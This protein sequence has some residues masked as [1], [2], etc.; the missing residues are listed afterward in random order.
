MLGQ[1]NRYLFK[2]VWRSISRNPGRS[3]F[4]GFSVSLAVIIAVW[5]IAFFDGLNH[6]IEDAVV[7]ANV[8]TFQIQEANYARSTDS[9]HPEVFTEELRRKIS[10]YDFL[11][12]SP[13]LVLDSNI[14]TPEG[15]AG[16]ITIGI[17]PE[18]HKSFLP[19]GKNMIEGNFIRPTDEQE[20]VIGEELANEFKFKTGDQLVLNYQD[21]QGELRSEILNIKGIYR[22]NGNVFERRFAYISQ[23]TWQKL[24]LNHDSGKILFN[25]ITILADG[26]HQKND[27]K[28]ILKGTPFKLKTWKQLNPEMAVV[29]EFHDGMIK[30]FFLIIAITI[31]MT[32]LT[33]IRMLWQERFKEMRMLSTLG[34]S[35]RKF[36]K[37]GLFENI[38][39]IG[40]SAIF[41]SFV[42]SI[43]IGV[44]SYRG[45]DFRFLN[46]GVAIDRAGIQMPGIVYP[47]LSGKQLMITFLFVVFVLSSSYVYSVF[48][49]LKKLKEEL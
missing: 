20:V 39:M 35:I 22:L 47:L 14:S 29:L 33:P 18:L 3:F 17:D 5:V 23:K 16:L 42:L 41:S 9:S 44:Q 45:V 43:I 21:S 26:I 7:K 30:F 11:A 37:I 1:E 8:G 15:T 2:Y 25:R 19:L 12:Y 24:F 28:E 46:N 4:I 32:I 48:E 49:T 6:Q 40:L 10:G 36:W 31:T 13:E 34:V 38:V 27:V